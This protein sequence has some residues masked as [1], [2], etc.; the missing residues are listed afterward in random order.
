MQSLGNIEGKL[1]DMEY[2]VY[3]DENTI[4]K[5]QFMAEMR[6]KEFAKFPYLYQGSMAEEKE[7]AKEYQVP[8]AIL[9]TCSVAGEDIGVISG[10]PYQY[11]QGKSAKVEVE[12]AT[13]GM[14]MDEIYYIG[15]V[16]LIEKYRNQGIGKQLEKMLVDIIKKE[17]K[18]ALVITVERSLDDPDRPEGY[19]Y[20]NGLREGTGFKRLQNE[21]VY[22]WP[23]K[24]K[25][26]ISEE[27]NVVS[28]WVKNI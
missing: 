22:S 13:M 6:L 9:I 11:N 25:S 15:E 12:L 28:V 26:G 18:Y 16:I 2:K 7:Y 24:R 17:Y 3:R 10:Y 19:R 8:G 23:V 14:A 21:I 20:K 4:E 5:F 27:E 1:Y